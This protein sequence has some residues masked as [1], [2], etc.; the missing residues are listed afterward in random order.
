MIEIENNR[1]STRTYLNVFK[2]IYTYSHQ[3]SKIR[4]I[5]LYFN[6]LISI[7]YKKIEISNILLLPLINNIITYLIPKKIKIK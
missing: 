6:E 1:R 3:L 4:H 7:K 5:Y 2:H